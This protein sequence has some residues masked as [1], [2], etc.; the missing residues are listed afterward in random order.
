MSAQARV[1]AQAP[2]VWVAAALVAACL[3]TWIVVVDRM[4]GMDGGPGTDLGGLGWYVGI[5][6]TMMAAMMLPSAAPMVL[7]FA[8][9]YAG[10][11]ER[12]G[13][14][15]PSWIF[16]GGYLAI[17]TAIGLAAY[18]LYRG[19]HALDPGFLGWGEQGPIVA[20]VAVAAAGVYEVTPLKRVCLR[21]C[22]GPLHFLLH[23]WR[24][25]RTGALHMGAEHGAWCVGCCVGLMVVLFAVGVMSVLWMAVIAALIFAE[26]VLPFGEGLTRVLAVAFIAAGI[27]IA[28]APSTVPGLTQPGTG[29]EMGGT[30]MESPGTGPDSGTEPMAP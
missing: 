17:W 19:V 13:P 9:V 18:G 3:V 25:G 11:A 24:E 20:G 7:L 29:M 10:R 12:G 15:V 30:D 14:F 5:W 2:A 22:R 27:W 21:H 26:K 8:R 28:A 16:V 1:R 4:R 23:G 6:V